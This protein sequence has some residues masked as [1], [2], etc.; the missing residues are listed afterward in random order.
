MVW[1]GFYSQAELWDDCW[2]VTFRGDSGLYRFDL[3]CSEKLAFY[4]L[5]DIMGEISLLLAGWDGRTRWGGGG[6]GVGLR[7]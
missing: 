6:T 3:V 1:D 2:G 7:D 5:A 4:E